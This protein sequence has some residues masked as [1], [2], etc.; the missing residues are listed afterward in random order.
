M[1]LQT[2]INKFLY[3]QKK[4]NTT[5]WSWN[6]KKE[7]AV[8]PSIIYPCALA[9]EVQLQCAMFGVFHVSALLVICKHRSC[10]L[11]RDK[12]CDASFICIEALRQTAEMIKIYDLACKNQYR[13]SP[14]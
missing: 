3:W 7:E 13:E 5:K 4:E 2:E 9:L 8:Y 11:L 12:Q 10:D 1:L 6:I 14:T